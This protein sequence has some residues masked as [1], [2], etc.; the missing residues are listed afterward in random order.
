MRTPKI[1]S[2]ANGQNYGIATDLQITRE[3]ILRQ[4]FNDNCERPFKVGESHEQ[5]YIIV[6]TRS[7]IGG[8]FTA[9]RAYSITNGQEFHKNDDRKDNEHQ[10]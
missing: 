10:N 1:K 6:N 5:V 9:R 8:I 4:I 7:G 2:S 3:F